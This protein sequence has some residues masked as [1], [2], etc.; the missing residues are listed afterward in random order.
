VS[1]PK[2]G[3]SGL[4]LSAQ[5]FAVQQFASIHNI[6]ILA[7]HVEVETGAGADA[8]DRRPKLKEALADA[9]RAKCPV[10]V[11]KLD[12]LSRDVHFISGLMSEKVPFVVA[13]LG[14]D[15]DPFVLHMFAAFAESERRRISQR[16]SDALQT[17]KA[18]GQ[19]LG[20]PRLDEAR[21]KAAESVMASAD[22]FAANVLPIVQQIQ[23]AGIVTQGDI[24]Q[25]LNARGIKTVRGG[26]WHGSTVGNLLKR[27]A[28][29]ET[30]LAK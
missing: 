27:K 21:L 30:L 25:A 12:R 22:R 14:R 9:R 16:T 23:A 17:K 24:A 29:V 3:R 19:K 11:S 8:L 13:E 15:V 26:V 7:E 28:N 5:R 18:A 6:E 2:Q 10:I 1:D 20:N 4:G